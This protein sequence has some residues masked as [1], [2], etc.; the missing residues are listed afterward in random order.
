[1]EASQTANN[2]VQTDTQTRRIPSKRTLYLL[3]LGALLLVY[4]AFILY[5]ERINFGLLKPSL[6]IN[7]LQGL[8]L[9]YLDV[10]VR[11]ARHYVPIILGWMLAYE[12]SLNLLLNLYDL[13]DRK[14]ASDL[15]RR[16]RDPRLT[17]GNVITVSPKD[18]EIKRLEST[19]LRLGGP[20]RIIIPEG[21]VAVSEIN[22][23]FYRVINSGK[24]ALDRFEYIHSVLDLRPQDRTDPEVKLQS[25][26]GLGLVTDVSVTF[27]ID[28][29]DSNTSIEQPFPYDVETVRLLAYNESN[30]PN[31]KIS[32]WEDNALVTVR[33]S[34]YASV[35]SFSLDQLL[36]DELT[37]IGTHL[38]IR[39]DVERDAR[40]KLRE[41]GIDLIRVRI[42]GFRFSDD[43]T[44][45]RI[46]NWRTEWENQARL[47]RAEGEA[48]ALEEM[49]MARAN[50][51]IDL[52]KAISEGIQ[53]ARRQG[54]QGNIRE[55]VSLRFIELLEK[56]AIESG[57]EVRLPDKL[58]PQLQDLHKQLQSSLGS[59]TVTNEDITLS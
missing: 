38:T 51:E 44:E 10:F 21:N 12:L 55:I 31:G 5:L 17:A 35:S 52:V 59:G 19:R 41:Q 18:L 16:L 46:Q 23:R 53:Q 56:M 37:Q 39:R 13:L 11:V 54:Y 34:L 50:A 14:K 6:P 24:H 49:E 9:Q 20:G 48:R 1:M 40:V 47:I 26:E 29:P 28:S 4:T 27:K 7:D 45:L 43:V 25:K 22:G 3:F 33:G 2:Q 32:S 8:L 57:N 42:G 58:L 15:L 30:L 36:Q